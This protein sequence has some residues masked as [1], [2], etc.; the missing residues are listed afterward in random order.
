MPI[1]S[2]AIQKGGSGKTT[3]ALNLAAAFREMGRKVLLVDLDPQS[4]LTQSMGFVDELEPNVYQLLKS[5]AAGMETDARSAIYQ[6]NGIDLIPAN[7]ELSAA[8]ME[9]VSVYGRE[10]LLKSILHPLKNQY[11]YI[12]IDCPPS[13]GMLTVNALVVSD[14][15]LMPLQAEYLPLKGLRSFMRAFQGILK[16]NKNLQLLGVLLTRFDSRLSM[17]QN[18]LRQ[19][20]EEYGEQVFINKIKT[21]IALAKAQER[22]LDIFLHDESSNGALNYMSLAYEVEGRI[23]TGKVNPAKP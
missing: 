4:N 1:L 3:T 9:L 23:I 5:E 12:I 10:N 7:L 2:I 16:L 13:I 19:L 14:Y 15:I 8:E 17:N 11:D 21:N 18:I 6:A 20:E 22:G